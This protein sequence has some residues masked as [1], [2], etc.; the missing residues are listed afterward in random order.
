MD[1][2]DRIAERLKAGEKPHWIAADMVP[3]AP[4][5]ALW[6]VRR[7]PLFCE[8][9]DPQVAALAKIIATRAARRHGPALG[10]K[11]RPVRT[12]LPCEGAS[13]VYTANASPG[14]D[15]YQF[16]GNPIPFTGGDHWSH[17]CE[18][19]SVAALGGAEAYLTAL[20]EALRAGKG[21]EFEDQFAEPEPAVG[22]PKVK[23]GQGQ[24]TTL[25]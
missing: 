11:P 23:R 6:W 9:H 8:H 24:Q 12:P 1:P 7:L 17:F 19:G 20:V 13:V 22:R 2:L 18:A 4:A 16:E 3:S 10:A 5:E 14:R 21:K 15:H 25:F